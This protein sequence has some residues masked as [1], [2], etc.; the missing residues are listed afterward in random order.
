MKDEIKIEITVPEDMGEAFPIW[1]ACFG[2]SGEYINMFLSYAEGH[3]KCLL[4]RHEGKAVSMFFLQ[5]CSAEA[6]PAY[7]LY[8]A[9]T[10]PEYR[11]RGIMG[12]MIEAAANYARGEGKAFI[13]L[14]PAEESLFGYY[15][16]F[17]FKAAFSRKI[18]SLNG[19][20]SEE[21][22]SPESGDSLFES[23]EKILKNIPHTRWNEAF[24]SYAERENAFFG[25]RTIRFGDSYALARKIGNEALIFELCAE[26]EAA[27]RA[28]AEEAMR[29]FGCETAKIYLP[30]QSDLFKNRPARIQRNGMALALGGAELKDDG[31]LGLT[32]E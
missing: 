12:G 6:H 3:C 23:R 20:G 22:A 19:A 5:E 17:G 29:S 18:V 7:Y 15:E 10:L 30:A 16:K 31:Y 8:A 21:K 4:A 32:L 2:D 9:A 27:A 25:G 13:I 11:G 1:Q 14:S 26:D 24:L 28:I